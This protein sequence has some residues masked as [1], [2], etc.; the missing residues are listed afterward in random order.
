VLERLPV[1]RDRLEDRVETSRCLAV[2]LNRSRPPPPPPRQNTPPSHTQILKSLPPSWEVEHHAWRQERK[3][4]SGQLK[5]YP[6][7]GDARQRVSGGADGGGGGD[8]GVGGNG[9]DSASSSAADPASYETPAD[10]EDNVR[11]MKRR[12][13]DKL[14]L[15]VKSSDGGGAG[16]W[17]FPSAE[18]RDGETIRATAERALREAI[19]ERAPLFFIGNAPMAHLEEGERSGGG[20]GSSSSSSSSSSQMGA[21][22]SSAPAAT[23][24]TFFHLAQVLNDPWE[25]ELA[26][27]GVAHDFAWVAPD[28]LD[29]YLGGAA[30]GGGAG[31]AAAAAARGGRPPPLLELTRR[32]L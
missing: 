30:G 27:G 26:R 9:G 22:A 14:V 11:T 2:L 16:G 6:Q 19:G 8:S 28:E 3:L 12:L 32:M 20:G 5:R 1:S 4:A 21:A 31:A 18:H 23:T 25:V 7:L 17:R 15:L 10:R 13:R 29:K 24:K